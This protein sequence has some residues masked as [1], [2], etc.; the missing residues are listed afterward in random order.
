[1]TRKSIIINSKIINDSMEPI[2]VIV[3]NKQD[4]LIK[5]FYLIFIKII[6]KFFYLQLIIA[7]TQ[8]ASLSIKREYKL[9]FPTILRHNYSIF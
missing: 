7:Y 9:P 5:F 4:Y 3:S 1:M 8:I 2:L 6:N